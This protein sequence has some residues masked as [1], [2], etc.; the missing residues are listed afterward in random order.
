MERRNVATLSPIIT[1]VVRPGSIIHTDEWGAY[2][3]ISMDENYEQRKIV[4]KYHFVDLE[5]GVQ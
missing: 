2:N 4:H 5:T 3:E 1:R